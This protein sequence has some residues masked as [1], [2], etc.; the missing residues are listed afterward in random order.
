MIGSQYAVYPYFIPTAVALFAQDTHNPAFLSGGGRIEA[1]D[2][3]GGE[4]FG[5]D[6]DGT[7]PWQGLVNYFRYIAVQNNAVV[8]I[9][10]TTY[11]P[12]STVLTC[13][14]DPT[15][16]RQVQQ[17]PV[18]LDFVG[19][20]GLNYVYAYI[21]SRNQIILAREDRNIVTWKLIN[22]FN[23]DIFGEKDD[24]TSGAYGYEY[25]IKYTIDAYNTFESGEPIPTVAPSSSSSGM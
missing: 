5:G 3:I 17:N 6:G 18:N 14:Y 13:L 11:P 25:P 7:D 16:P 2:W 24:G 12:C 19:P 23:S 22:Q 4:T 9:G 15:D 10:T 8:T 20:D 1:K 21:Q